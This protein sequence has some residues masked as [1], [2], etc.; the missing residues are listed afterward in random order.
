M[1]GR[2][3]MAINRRWWEE[4]VAIHV[5]S[6]FYDVESFLAGASKPMV[7]ERKELGSVKGKS[8]LHL[9]CHFGL[10]TLSWARYGARVTGL[11]FSANA[12]AAAREIADKAGLKAHFIESNIYQAPENLNSSFDIVFTSWGVL[13]WLPDH[14]RWAEIVAHFLK[15]GGVFYIAEIHPFTEIFSQDP[16][17]VPDKN[18]IGTFEYDYFGGD[19]PLAEDSP[20]TYADRNAKTHDNDSRYWFTQLGAV[21]NHLIEAGLNIEFI[22]EHD[23]SCFQQWP[24]MREVAPDVWR[25]PDDWPRL[26]LSFSIRARKPS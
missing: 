1:K 8:L 15:P 11:D 23:F 16:S 5:D 20:G 6:D 18:P 2:N 3:H 12:V 25:L 19:R 4:R 21:A 13:S 9:Q 14:K 24:A 26:P 7:L 10:D 17:E 22:H